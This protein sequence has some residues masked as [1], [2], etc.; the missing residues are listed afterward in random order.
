MSD[1]NLNLDGVIAF[2]A[3]F[4]LGLLLLLAILVASIYA[5]VKARRKHEPF[6][7]QGLAPH[8]VGM[9]VSVLACAAVVLLL[10]FGETKLLPRT[11]AIWFDRWLVVWIAAVLA[12]WPL[13]VVSWKQLRG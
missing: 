3:A 11:L 2:L 13:S 12:L 5:T 10:L 1:I 8:I 4:G 9:L 7:R 6:R